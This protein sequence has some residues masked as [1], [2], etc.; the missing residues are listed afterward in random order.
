MNDEVDTA[1]SL[2]PEAPDTEPRPASGAEQDDTPMGPRA[3]EHPDVDL[4]RIRRRIPE[5]LEVLEER[6]VTPDSFPLLQFAGRHKVVRL[7]EAE[8][9]QLE[10]WFFIGDIHGDFFALH[11]LLRAAEEHD[12]ECR[13]LFLGDMVD[14]G[15]LPL[16]CVFLF[17]EWALE[18]PGRALWLAGNHDEAL[19]VNENGR[20]SSKVKPAELLDVLN[21]LDLF[22]GF[23]ERLGRFL[24]R[25]A[26]E[27][28]RAV[29][30][31]DGLLATHGGFPLSDRHAE[32]QTLEDEDAY[33][34][35][36]NSHGC[37]LDFTWTRIHKA[38]K[39][40]PN[41][42]T[43]GSQYGYR[44]FEAFCA[45]KPEWFPVQRMITGHEHPQEGYLIQDTYAI[46]QALTLK[47][48]GFDDLRGSMLAAY[49]A[50]KE[51]LWL[52]RGVA[53]AL[54]ELLEVPVN[55]DELAMMPGL[56]GANAAVPSP[57]VDPET[58]S[59]QTE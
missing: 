48:F 28:P 9:G 44:D 1:D 50:Y 10:Q 37:L 18:R 47:G 54:P 43:L 34:D 27:L 5:L 57:A 49:Q 39:K 32:G 41:R 12:A 17:L 21:A 30:F 56:L 51:S 11:T 33:L 8:A 16:E 45:L 6:L 7:S 29:L 35:W 40:I 38:P 4:A 52:A 19:V 24:L 3:L 20:F 31:P 15:D 25:L 53:G 2:L 36:L 14:R 58:P 23:R 46:N 42:Y 22:Q 59:P 55:R 13:V 26:S